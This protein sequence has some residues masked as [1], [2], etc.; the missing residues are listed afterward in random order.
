VTSRQVS[1]PHGKLMQMPGEACDE[2]PET[3]AES[4]PIIIRSYEPVA[5]LE[6]RLQRI[7]AVLSLPPLEEL[8]AQGLRHA[9]RDATD[10]RRRRAAV[11]VGS[12]D[13]CRDS[14]GESG[15]SEE[16]EA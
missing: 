3:A 9:F 8:H 13:R 12:R 10:R 15:V 5:D 1:D 4:Y 6:D 7:F 11:G 14:E 2:E 16:G